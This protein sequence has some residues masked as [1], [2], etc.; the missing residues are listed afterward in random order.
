M[1]K[2]RVYPEAWRGKKHLYVDV[3]VFRDRKAMH[4]DIKSGHFGPANNCHGQCSGIAHYDKR[5]KLTG[6]FAIMWLNAEDL[7]AKPA[8]IVAH[9]SI[10][11]AMRHMKN[12]SVDLSDM[13]GEEA[14]CYCAGSMTQQINDRLYRAKVFA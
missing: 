2:M 12:K 10:H 4:R 5:G 14:L 6:K 13:A 9:E 7:R 1:L 11:A 8:E 3:R